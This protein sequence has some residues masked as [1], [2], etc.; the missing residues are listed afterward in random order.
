MNV[1]SLK[2]ISSFITEPLDYLSNHCLRDGVFPTKLKRANVIPLYE[3]AFE[4]V[5][6]DRL[7]DFLETF[8]ILNNF[9][10]GFMHSTNMALITHWNRLITSLEND[11][12]VFGIYLDFDTVDHVILLK[13]QYTMV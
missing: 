10:F 5:M 12:Y 8:S 6:Y 3:L 1:S 7:I 11:E 9:H 4:K 13:S 2:H